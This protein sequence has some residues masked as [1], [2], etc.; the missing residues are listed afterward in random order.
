KMAVR[1]LR[2]GKAERDGFSYDPRMAVRHLSSADATLATLMKRAGP[3]ALRLRHMHN[4]F[5]ALARNI[6][7]QQLHGSAAEAIRRRVLDL[8]G[9]G[10]L[11]PQ[12]VLAAREEDLRAAGLSGAKL[13]ALR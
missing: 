3:F 13:A 8:F 4:P 6:I 5:E 10:K 1:K 2:I 7:F 12:D 9:K 11:R